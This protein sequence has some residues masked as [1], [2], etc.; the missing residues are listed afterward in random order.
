MTIKAIFLYLSTLIMSY[1]PVPSY[2]EGVIDQPKSF[3]PNEARSQHENSV[4][5]LIFRGLFKY[6]IYGE[7]VPDLAETW[8]ISEDGLTY[9][10]TIKDGNYWSNGKKI[11]S[12]DIIYTAFKMPAL[13]GVATD[14]VDDRTVIFTLP[15][16]YAPFLSLLTTGVMPLDAVEKGN[17]LMPVTN[18]DFT[19]ARI[20]RTGDVVRKLT[21]YSK[22]ENYKIKKII[23]KY[24]ANEDELTTAAKLG[25]INAFLSESTHEITNFEDYKF[26]IQGIYYAVYFNLRDDQLGDLELRKKLEKV[27]PM[28]QLT[29]DRGITVQGPVSRSSF[30]DYDLKFDKY[31]EKFKDSLGD[32]KLKLTVPD[33]EKHV[34][35]AE[36]IADLWQAK[37]D[38]DISIEK[39]DQKDFFSKVIEPRNFQ[40]LLYGQEVGRDPDRYSNWY[41]TEKDPPGLNLSGFSQVRADRALEEGRKELNNDKRAVH[42]NELQ[43]SVL[44]NV[45]VIFLYHPFSNYYVSKYIKGIGEK[46]TFTY[47][48][49]FLDFYNWENVQTN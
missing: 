15:N 5:S 37:L 42:Y 43:K 44:D 41:S 34:E 35:M 47:S 16:K 29:Y 32:L 8:E 9:K 23:F 4:S 7:L 1:M 25:E 21:I 28:N 14:K 27:L 6:D 46:Y 36:R 30:T 49:R 3:L 2:V 38:L 10:I 17:K 40:M 48:D 18:G 45:P 26:P 20:E 12:D 19:I 39:V 24:Y 13:E 33:T 11:T 22:N 31:D